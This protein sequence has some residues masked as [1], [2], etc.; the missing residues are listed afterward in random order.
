[1]SLAYFNVLPTTPE[2]RSHETAG[3]VVFTLIEAKR[4]FVAISEKVERLDVPARS[5]ER[6]F[7]QRREVFQPVPGFQS[8]VGG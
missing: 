5:F 4:L 1:M 6:A 3:I 7:E 8:N 2:K